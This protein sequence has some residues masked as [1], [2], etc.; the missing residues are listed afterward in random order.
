MVST[1]EDGMGPTDAIQDVGALIDSA[2]RNLR[3]RRATGMLDYLS[4]RFPACVIYCGEGSASFHGTVLDGL[5]EG[6]GGKASRIPCVTIPDPASLH[7]IVGSYGAF[8]TAVVDAGTGSPLD[9]RGFQSMVQ[10]MMGSSGI[11]ESMVQCSLFF[12]LNSSG[13]TAE[14]FSSWY[15]V[16]SDVELMLHGLQTRTMLI[17]LL[18]DS[19]GTSNAKEIKAALSSLYEDP[20]VR[21]E[22]RH[23]YD[24]VFL[25][26]NLSKGGRYNR[27]FSAHG[28][29]ENGDWDVVSSVMVLANSSGDSSRSCEEL[30]FSSGHEAGVTAAFKQVEKPRR[31]I[32]SVALRRI[33]ERLDEFHASVSEVRPSRA[34]IE[35][36]LGFSNGRSDFMA[37]YGGLS[38]G[39]INEFANFE[40]YLPTLRPNV[41]VG[42]LT[43]GQANAETCGCLTA[44]VYENHLAR[45]QA[46]LDGPGDS[47]GLSDRIVQRLAASL[48]AVKML[49]LR[50]DEWVAAASSLYSESYLQGMIDRLP[51]LDALRQMMRAEIARRM[52][53]ETIRAI[54]MLYAE[55]ERTEDA[56]ARLRNDVALGTSVNEE[57]THF[58]LTGFYGRCT[59]AYLSDQARL[60]ALFAITDRIGNGEAEMFAVLRDR[61]LTPLF[62]L[63]YGGRQV[64]RLGFMEEQVTRRADGK[65][66]EA[67][68]LVVGSELVDN[69]A[70][71]V[72]YNSLIPMTDQACEAYLLHSEMSGGGEAGQLY[73]YLDRLG[74]PAGTIRVF[75]SAGPRDC[76]TSLWL[77]PLKSDHLRA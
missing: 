27:L 3:S 45:L 44:F 19:L 61:A 73:A 34:E 58:N 39:V 54:E 76:A 2:A 50:K 17:V 6:W 33:V 13:M 62:D 35:R 77:Y 28:A 23:L 24:G 29:E 68:Q 74:K 43:F 16:V 69:M 10:L 48:T 36:A 9:V 20:Q 14:E 70:N 65:A 67:A 51:M 55:A 56:F 71:Y 5:Q 31:D 52:R 1:E 41:N 64:F 32:V 66:P 59:D 18:D 30:L 11:F 15:G 22:R 40:L 53:E 26:G 4:P 63:D 7:Q 25:Y 75:M 42:T 47:L 57:G 46:I 49:S 37:E 12:V 8:G 38:E 72:G 60:N 21:A